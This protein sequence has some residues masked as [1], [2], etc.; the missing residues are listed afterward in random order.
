MDPIERILIEER[1]PAAYRDIVDWHWRPLAARI[2]AWRRAMDRPLVVG[3]NGAQGSGKT[4]LCRFLAEALLPEKGFS[5]EVL[6]L[7]DLYLPMRERQAMAATVHPLF[8]TRGVPGTHDAALGMAV[9]DAWQAGAAGVRTPRFDKA[10]DDRAGW[11]TTSQAP[12]VILF[13]GWC[14]GARP[15]ADDR[16]APAV[17]ALEAEEDA[18]GRWR[19]AVN[20]RL[21]GDYAEWFA[22]ID[23]LVMLVPPD[24][25][26][27]IA[28]R[29]RQE[30]RLRAA[31]G[32]GMEDAALARFMQH[33]ERLTRWMFAEMPGRA[34]AV[35]RLDRDQR[36]I[37]RG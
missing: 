21:A 29:R 5:A 7:D 14:V 30:D 31:T 4:T 3:I 12:D 2:A 20:A 33:Y 22:R 11:T 24:W 15:E 18:D 10:S 19:R 25:D 6:A 34:D 36:P 35:I 37:G 16:L 27:V 13:E 1:L 26:A 32:R 17:N 23:R 28:N 9:L 8:A